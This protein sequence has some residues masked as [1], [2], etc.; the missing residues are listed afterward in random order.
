[1]IAARELGMS[2]RRAWLLLASLNTSFRGRVAVTATGGRGGGGARVTRFRQELIAL[3]RAFEDETQARAARTFKTITAKARRSARGAGPAS[4]R[5]LT[6]RGA[7]A[8]VSRP[9]GRLRTA[10]AGVTRAQLRCPA[11]GTGHG[12]LRSR[13]GARA[14]LQ[15]HGCTRRQDEFND[16]VGS[17]AARSPLMILGGNDAAVRNHIDP[18][19][20]IEGDSIYARGSNRQSDETRVRCIGLRPCA[21]RCRERNLCLPRQLQC[22]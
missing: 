13:N 8:N 10:R 16:F 18:D 19:R 20:Q 1:M 21:G 6:E 3:Y 5:H 14:E 15:R 12:D 9:A 7:A 11:G 17:I 22:I 4:V 2:Y